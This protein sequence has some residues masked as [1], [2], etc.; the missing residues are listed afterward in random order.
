MLTL[1]QAF[2]LI[3]YDPQGNLLTISYTGGMALTVPASKLETC[4][5]YLALYELS[6]QGRIRSGNKVELADPTPTGDIVLDWMLDAVRKSLW[7]RDAGDWAYHLASKLRTH[8]TEL[9]TEQLIQ[10]GCLRREPKHVLGVF[11]TDLFP[12]ADA[13]EEKAMKAHLRQVV[14]GELPTD[15]RT[16]QLLWSVHSAKLEGTIF[17]EEEEQ[18]ARQR[19][20][21]LLA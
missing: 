19:I 13:T 17:P 6:E 1:T 3:A 2:T 10:M 5:V 16:K 20:E 11:T 9:S 12:A 4:L 18:E 21:A 8:L 14:R 7:K 15:R